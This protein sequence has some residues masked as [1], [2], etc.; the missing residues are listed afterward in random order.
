MPE[1]T[2]DSLKE[3]WKKEKDFYR[4]AEVGSGVQKFCYKLF[5]SS[6]LFNLKEGKGS[7]KEIKRKNEFLEEAKKKSRR[8]DV[9]I[10]IDSEIII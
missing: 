1:I 3:L 9:V 7:T 2:L 8:A 5:Q 4:S 10:F 6:E